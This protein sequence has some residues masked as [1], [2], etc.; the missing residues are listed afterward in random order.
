MLLDSNI[1]IYLS[2]GTIKKEFFLNRRLLVS[3]ITE[4]EVLGFH[5]L[6]PIEK[7]EY[8]EFFKSIEVIP[9]NL[10]VKQ[11]AIKLKQQ[12]KI[13]I[14][15]SIIA[16]TAIVHKLPLVTANSKDFSWIEGLELI[17]PL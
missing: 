9:I 4:I 2:K 15:D 5:N 17:N 6:S 7:N 10:D 3:I 8:L 12:R 1:V 13:G 11:L 14:A 16:A